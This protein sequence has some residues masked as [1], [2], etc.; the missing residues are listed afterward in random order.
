VID[1]LLKVLAG[2]AICVIGG[3]AVYVILDKTNVK[4]KIR[5]AFSQKHKNKEETPF[6]ARVRDKGKSSVRFEVFFSK[7]AKDAV[8]HSTNV[9]DFFGSSESETVDVEADAVSDDIRE[10]ELIMLI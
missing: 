10:G 7:C 8:E 2:V 9:D 3:A 5:D 4:D 6:A 1:I